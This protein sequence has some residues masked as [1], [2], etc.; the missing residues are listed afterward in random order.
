M[1]LKSF[2]LPSPGDILLVAALVAP[3]A[4]HVPD[5]DT[6]WHLAAG[7][8]MLDHGQ[9]MKEDALSFTR[10][11]EHWF[12]HEWLPEIALAAV[13]S[14]FGLDALLLLKAVVNLVTMVLLWRVIGVHL[15]RWPLA[16]TAVAILAF[17]GIVP[18]LT[19]RPWM[20][21]LLCFAILLELWQRKG[22]WISR[23]IPIALLLA[24]WI[25]LHGMFALG[26]LWLGM[27]VAAR[28]VSLAARPGEGE[29]DDTLAVAG[30][31]MGL[32][33]L[34][35]LVHPY[36]WRILAYPFLYKGDLT[37]DIQEWLPPDPS[38]AYG[39]Y[40]LVL[41]TIL[42]ATFV[43]AGAPPSSW[44][45]V[46]GF[47]AL[48]FTA[49]R[50]VPLLAIGGAPPLAE[51][52][53]RLLDRPRS[54]GPSALAAFAWRRFDNFNAM[55]A[56]ARSRYHLLV[57]LLLAPLTLAGGAAGAGALFRTPVCDRMYPVAASAWLVGRPGTASRRVFN[58]YGW[59]GYLIR[60]RG[61]RTFI[62]GRT[63]LFLPD[64]LADYRKV[65][66]IQDGW[67]DVLA[68]HRI[69]TVLFPAGHALGQLLAAEG[70]FHLVYADHVAVIYERGTAGP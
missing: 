51:A 70:S 61:M 33:S 47:G 10:E 19:P 28:L 40:L 12:A 43:R 60:E 58:F 52:L 27:Q 18:V 48:A 63:D 31:A 8:W 4:V 3:I 38:S 7:Q 6:W 53:S 45:V 39:R 23:A 56:T 32:G 26:F 37:R 36:G 25:N 16:R 22:G 11:G 65:S 2:L 24:L 14:R 68:R 35:A 44:V 50:H 9:V 29:R 59:G 17:G 46:A 55:A 15:G 5:S 64:V 42:I 21:S 67:A 57:L 20:F 34:G 41:A 49:Q 30:T 69:D 13:A 66:G 1:G 62:D 54:S